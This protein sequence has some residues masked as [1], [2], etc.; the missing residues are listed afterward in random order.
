MT[1]VS[2]PE[3]NIYIYFHCVLELFQILQTAL[4]ARNVDQILAV[5]QDIPIFVNLL[6]IVLSACLMFSEI[7]G[8]NLHGDNSLQNS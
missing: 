1:G 7:E 8:C 2:M 6:L 5:F 3:L 4:M